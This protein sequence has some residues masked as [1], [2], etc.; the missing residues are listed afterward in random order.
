LDINEQQSTS[1]FLQKLA[2][3]S[4]ELDCHVAAKACTS[5]FQ[6]VPMAMMREGDA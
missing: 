3:R 2:R 5:M 1:K 4:S 6:C